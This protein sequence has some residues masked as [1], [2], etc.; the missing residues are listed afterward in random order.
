MSENQELYD[1]AVRCGDGDTQLDT[2]AADISAA[3]NLDPETARLGAEWGYSWWQGLATIPPES[4][5][6]DIIIAVRDMVLDGIPVPRDSTEHRPTFRVRYA[7]QEALYAAAGPQME[8]LRTLLEGSTPRIIPDFRKIDSVLT[9]LLDTYHRSGYPYNLDSTRVPQD[10]RHMPRN[11]NIDPQNRTPQESVKLASFWFADCYYMRGVNDSNDMTVNLAALHEQHPEIFDFSIAAQMEPTDIEQLLLEYHLAVQHKQTSEHWVENARR[12]MQRYDGNPLHIFE[13]AET[14][15]ELVARVRNDGKGSGFKGFQKK[16]TSML[17]YFYMVSDL[18]PY[19]NH[20]LPVDFHV[21]RLSV[22]HELVKFEYLPP[23]GVIPFDATTDFLREIFYDFADHHNVSQLELCDV[24]WLFSRE[25][26]SLSP[27]NMM[28]QLG[29]YAARSTQLE[30]ALT[31]ADDATPQQHRQYDRS[32]GM[33]V[34][35]DTCVHNVPSALYYKQGIVI[36][37]D[38]KIRLEQTH[39]DMYDSAA[40]THAQAPVR[41]APTSHA[42]D[43]RSSQRAVTK[44]QRAAQIRYLAHPTLDGIDLPSAT[45]LS[46]TRT[47]ILEALGHQAAPE[48]IEQVL[49]RVTIIER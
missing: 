11:L 47:E 7:A 32:C 25:L 34:V 43:L 5:D 33:C 39:D 3:H 22:S 44:Q 6:P 10:P 24:V 46:F 48:D 36:V 2:I 1:R 15:D 16:M 28:R 12:M 19:R 31:S 41:P 40:I 35:A 38:P 20:P 29:A 37:P 14:Y 4:L 45:H 13:G 49:S 21:I 18:V 30:P 9:T 27:G 8:L 23:T 26:C 17:S 42:V